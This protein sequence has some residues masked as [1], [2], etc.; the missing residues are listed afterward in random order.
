MSLGVTSTGCIGKSYSLGRPEPPVES[1]GAGEG[2]AAGA[3]GSGGNSG[4]GM[5]GTSGAGGGAGEGA[6][7]PMTDCGDGVLQPP[8]EC[9]DDN[10]VAGD[11]CAACAT[12]PGFRCSSE[13]SVCVDI[14]ECEIDADNCDDT[15]PCKN[16]V[17]SF[18]CECEDEYA[19]NGLACVPA[20]QAITAGG[21]HTCALSTMGAV[22]CWGWGEF[23]MH[24]YGNTNNIGDDETPASVGDVDL[25][26]VTQQLSAHDAHTCALSTTGTV[27]CWGYGDLLSY[28]SLGY[29]NTSD[30][31]DDE[32]PASGGEV[33]VGGT[34][35]QIAAG[36][37]HTCALLT[38]GTVRCWGWGRYGQLGYGNE[39]SIGDDELPASAGDVD[40]GGPVQQ[41]VAGRYHTCALLTSGAVRCWGYAEFG[42]LGYG[43]NTDFFPDTSEDVNNIGNNETPA[44][45]GDVN[46]GGAVQQIAAGSHNTCALL[47]S[48]AVRCWG[49]ATDGML[50]YGNT[51]NI[52][53]DETPAS[54][55]DVDVGGPVQQI[56]A[57]TGGACALLETGA[58]RCWG[59]SWVGGGGLG[60]GHLEA[61]GD[62]ETPASAGDL[63]IGGLV[64]QIAPG[65]LHICAL[66]SR[67]SVRCWGYADQGALGYGNLDE[68][69]DDETPASAGDVPI[70]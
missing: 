49:L 42:Q 56:A 55:G 8:E 26:S 60:Y 9:D 17:G 37:S 25:G 1:A 29:G 23:G 61:I 34:V 4:S 30:V 65:S 2:G 5:S 35:Q 38:T 12:E 32:T 41:I 10:S 67:G 68:I 13:P 24:G 48:G 54:A 40:V 31:G 63:D 53:D 51:N 39:N 50:G 45:V 28:G 18:D 70:F 11:G 44:S 22:R 47:T 7:D 62:D 20:V 36:G 33:N 46:V 52:G 21:A 57:G 15:A 16:T 27:R 64:Q 19:W 69:G 6:P 3:E 43:N 14:D 66:L 59:A 58:V